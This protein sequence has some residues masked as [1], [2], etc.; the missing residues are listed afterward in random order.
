VDRNAVT[1][2]LRKDNHFITFNIS[3]DKMEVGVG[4]AGQDQMFS[5]WLVEAAR[6]MWADRIEEGYQRIK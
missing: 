1:F 5:P 6:H 3:G 4:F 2:Q